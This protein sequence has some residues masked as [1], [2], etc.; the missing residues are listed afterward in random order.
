MKQTGKAIFTIRTA[1]GGFV[2]SYQRHAYTP[3]EVRELA[4]NTPA[5]ADDIR[6]GWDDRCPASRPHSVSVML[7]GA[8]A[9][10]GVVKAI[11]TTKP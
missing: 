1:D 10:H 9:C 6:K 4:R 3:V 11:T 7:F 5:L 2:H 8:M